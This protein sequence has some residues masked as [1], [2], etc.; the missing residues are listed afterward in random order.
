MGKRHFQKV[1]HCWA[2]SML[3]LLICWSDS[4]PGFPMA[5]FKAIEITLIVTFILMRVLILQWL[6]WNL[7]C[8][9]R[10]I[11]HV[12][13]YF[14]TLLLIPLPNL[15]IYLLNIVDCS[16][17]S[18]IKVP[19]SRVHYWSLLL[20][21]NLH[22]WSWITVNSFKCLRGIYLAIFATTLKSQK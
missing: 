18:G 4:G 9:E 20:I 16:A 6:S 13:I 2:A 21:S 19:N 14:E 10:Y 8:P 7:N 1:Q 5:K 22:I 15:V 11:H 17:S 3:L 12:H